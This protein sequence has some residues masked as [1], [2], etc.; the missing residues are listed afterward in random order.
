MS[1]GIA[2]LELLDGVRS[3]RITSAKQLN[4]EKNRVA[5][6]YSLSRVPSTIQIISSATELERETF[7]FVLNRKPTR[8]LSGVNVVAVMTKPYDCI[9]KCIYCPVSLVP[10][11]KTPKSYTGREPSTMRGLM[12]NF[13]PYKIV[14]NRLE[15]YRMTNNESSKIELILQGGTFP[16]L[17]FSHQKYFVKRCLDAVLG[18]NTSSLG[19]AK[20]LCESSPRRVVG[21]TIETRPDW[22]GKKEINRMLLLGATRVELGV[23]VPDDNVY[24]LINRGH[25]VKDVADSTSLLKDSCFKI[26]YHLMPGLYGSNFENDL[27]NFKR[28]FSES[29]FL[30]DMI[31]IYPTLVI[32]KTVLHTLWEK[33]LFSPMQSMEAAKLIVELKKFVPKYVRIM[34]VQRDIPS[35]VVAGG[36]MHTNLRQLVEAE[37]KRLGVKCQ[38]IRCREAGLNS[39]RDGIDLSNCSPELLRLDYDSSGGK[40]IFLSVEDKKNDLLFGFCRL[41][42][43]SSPFRKEITLRTGLIRELHVY[44]RSLELG[45]KP[46]LQEFQHKGFGKRLV[47]EAERI[48]KE[49]FD[50]DKLLVISGL[51]VKDYYKKNFG[52]IDDGPYV[53]KKL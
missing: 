37:Q 3:G 32:E 48:A 53:S 29:E 33:G 17:P 26:G 30:P 8:S 43:P 1:E 45:K 46:S 28:I 23:Q 38:C 19:A 12:F 34:R 18:Q 4:R 35:T 42:I 50:A 51:G 20:K 49:E 40:E 31:K 36:A 10:G 7:R 39:F 47:I 41:R 22:C 27:K 2:V 21:L 15:Q 9:G 24:R 16:E 5:K 6:K 13:N 44:T 14:E 11:R 52:C 25:K